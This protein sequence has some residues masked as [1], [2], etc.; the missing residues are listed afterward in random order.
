MQLVEEGALA[1][2]DTID[3][4]FPDQPNADK[5][6]VRMLL[7]HTSGLANA[8]LP[9]NERDAKWAEE[10]APL[11]FVAEANR[12]GPLAEPGTD[13]AHYSNAGYFLLGLIIEAVTG[14]S[15]EQEVRSR[16]NEPLGL[17]HTAF[18]DDEGIRRTIVEGYF[19]TPD[20]YVSS[21]DVSNLHASTAWAA[22]GVMSSIYRPAY[23]CQRPFRRRL[24]LQ[25]DTG[26]DDD[27]SGARQ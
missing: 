8:I 20:G 16:I 7:S 26:G 27:T 13:I 11:D 1:L 10:W 4:W 6:T 2:D 22:G 18:A 14:E 19:R 25:T 15:W 23:L 9:S 5:I 3:T 24:G 12:N 17:D 21:L